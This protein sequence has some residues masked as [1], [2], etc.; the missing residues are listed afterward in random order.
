MRQD[1]FVRGTLLWIDD[2]FEDIGAQ[3]VPAEVWHEVF[4]NQSPRLYRLMD[5]SLDL[6]AS[7]AEGREAIEFYD[8]TAAAGTF[9]MT[10]VDLS[11]PRHRGDLPGIRY[12]VAIAKELMRRDMPFVFL[13]T[14]SNATE[15]LD[16]E[17]LGHVPYYVKENKG[18]FLSTP[19]T[20]ALR[21]LSE[22]KSHIGWI[23]LEEII[24]SM[25]EDCDLARTSRNCGE[26]FPFYPYFGPFREFVERWEYEERLEFP[27]VFVVRASADSS[28]EYVQQSLAIML[29]ETL[30]R[31]NEQLAIR[32]GE[33]HDSDYMDRLRS[34]S[35]GRHNSVAVIRVWSENTSVVAF[36]D[37]VSDALERPGWTIFVIQTDESTDRFSDTLRKARIAAL[38]ELP[39]ISWGSTELRE[40]LV[41]RSCGLVFQHWH[42]EGAG[43]MALPMA[44]L[45]HPELLINPINW[46]AILEAKTIAIDLSDSYEVVD[47]LFKAI[48]GIDVDQRDAIRSSLNAELPVSYQNLLR[49][50]N[51]TLLNSE[52]AEDLSLWI[53]RAVDMWL[54]TSWSFPY[55]LGR[56]F[57]QSQHEISASSDEAWRCNQ[58][59][60]WQDAC[61]ESLVCMLNELTKHRTRLATTPREEDLNRVQRFVETLGGLRFLKDDYQNIDWEALESL[62]WPHHRYPIPATINRRLKDAGRYLWIQPERLD[63]AAALPEGRRRYRALAGIVDHYAATLNWAEKHVSDLPLGWAPNVQFLLDAIRN[64]EI[65]QI[66]RDLEGRR[67]LWSA[68]LTLLKN[69]TP[70]VFITDQI[71]RGKPLVGSRHSA[72]S[73]LRCVKGYGT[74]LGRLRA[75]ANRRRGGYLVKTWRPMDIASEM[76]K[77]QQAHAFQQLFGKVKAGLPVSLESLLSSWQRLIGVLASEYGS[78]KNLSD[79]VAD[80]VCLRM[81]EFFSDGPAVGDNDDDWFIP[82]EQL[83]SLVDI[84]P[85]AHLASLLGS[86]VDYLW[87]FLDVST[88]LS[89]ASH[90]YR[91]FDG[92]HFLASLNDLRVGSKDGVPP[93][94]VGLPVIEQ[95][96]DSFVF[97]LEGL[98]AQLSWCLAIAGYERESKALDSEH[99]RVTPPSDFTPPPTED[100]SQ[101]F[102]VAISER[103]YA[104]GTLGI[105]GEGVVDQ[106]CFYDGTQDRRL[107]EFT[108]EDTAQ[109]SYRQKHRRSL[110]GKAGKA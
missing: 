34:A 44:Y 67:R 69:A 37:L 46:V 85:E 87:Y 2:C 78:S 10:V 8:S 103:A 53:E 12:G 109:R 63:L 15:V 62:R 43:E 38:D 92:Y 13:S 27:R 21:V 93:Q 59:V 32:Y 77:V 70:V 105:P 75:S 4:G 39:H 30:L 74:I 3:E 52:T 68:L 5:L 97:A 84:W 11:L 80:E 23:S 96:M 83:A 88:S 51:E 40:E 72:K 73:F 76:T 29:Y 58:G 65:G 54:N 1:L 94:Q 56:Q 81:R 79:D 7:W 104:V 36:G 24:N 14:N 17:G 25:H 26:A 89:H 102:G 64:H 110:T 28:H 55:G 33:A 95:V 18:G 19:E 31:R 9:C 35:G 61:Y 42:S 50:G 49:V 71:I 90:P 107:S 101:V 108:S 99:V 66:W 48:R 86:K 91:H 20:L 57:V 60:K 41:R 82:Q 98:V 100:L 16:R 22:F 6:A 47:E 106:L 45:S